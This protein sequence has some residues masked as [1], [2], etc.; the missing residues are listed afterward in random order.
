[1]KGLRA[2]ELREGKEKLVSHP[3]VGARPSQIQM[4]DLLCSSLGYGGAI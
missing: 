1:M 4:R 2:N 3:E